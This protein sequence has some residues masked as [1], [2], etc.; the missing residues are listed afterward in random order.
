MERPGKPRIPHDKVDRFDTALKGIR[1]THSEILGLIKRGGSETAQEILNKLGEAGNAEKLRALFK[2]FNENVVPHIEIPASADR[3]ALIAEY[4]RS[5]CFRGIFEGDDARA[6]DE[7]LKKPEGNLDVDALAERV[8]DELDGSPTN[9]VEPSTAGAQGRQP[10]HADERAERPD[11]AHATPDETGAPGKQPPHAD[12]RAERP[13]AAPDETD[14]QDKQ[15]SADDKAK[16]QNAMELDDLMRKVGK[17]GAFETP[18]AFEKG[19]GDLRAHLIKTDKLKRHIDGHTDSTDVNEITARINGGKE[20]ITF[21]E[22]KTFRDHHEGEYDKYLKGTQGKDALDENRR[23]QE[24]LDVNIQRR[25]LAL[26]TV[27][28]TRGNLTDT[29]A[30]FQE[31]RTE[32]KDRGILSDK[33]NRKD[34]SEPSNIEIEIRNR[35]PISETELERLAE[36]YARISGESLDSVKGSLANPGLGYTQGRASSLAVVVD[37]ATK[38]MSQVQSGKKRYP[39]HVTKLEYEKGVRPN[40]L[41]S[42]FAKA[43]DHPVLTPLMAVGG[44]ALA[45]AVLGADQ[46]IRNPTELGLPGR[47]LSEVWVTGR[48]ESEDQS[49]YFVLTRLQGNPEIFAQFMKKQ[50]GFDSS[51]YQLPLENDP[52]PYNGRKNYF[53][54]AARVLVNQ[55]PALPLTPGLSQSLSAAYQ[56]AAIGFM[57]IGEQAIGTKAGLK[58]ALADYEA[59]V[60]GAGQTELSADSLRSMT[61]AAAAAHHGRRTVEPPPQTDTSLRTIDAPTLEKKFNLLSNPA[62]YRFDLKTVKE[63]KDGIIKIANKDSDQRALDTPDEF[64]EAAQWIVT[65][66]KDKKIT[67]PQANQLRALFG[68]SPN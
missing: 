4:F 6:F 30:F 55:D 25:I 45:F 8:A 23:L 54:S 33:L 56:H 68:L 18:E 29:L 27:Y 52:S 61:V 15:T 53:L 58:V 9:R 51:G 40:E 46:M 26:N 66:S 1:S 16:L 28:K 11:T 12:E 17:Y 37:V 59:K 3:E 57:G 20:P 39:S 63:I 48:P 13:D 67:E 19:L 50:F 34:F 36:L 44:A 49:A 38:I 32:L 42:V 64:R 21:A 47:L 7:L 14:A 10:P 65:L 62:V 43:A 35:R 60:A 2:D 5:L 41:R 22:W 24:Q 31:F